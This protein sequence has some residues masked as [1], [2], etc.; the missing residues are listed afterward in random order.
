M[1]PSAGNSSL[2]GD[3]VGGVEGKGNMMA[4]SEAGEL[5]EVDRRGREERECVLVRRRLLQRQW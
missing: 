3:N 1:Y 5:E 4:E 2:S